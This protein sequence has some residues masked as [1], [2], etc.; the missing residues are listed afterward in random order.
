MITVSAEERQA[1]TIAYFEHPHM[2]RLKEVIT[3]AYADIN[4]DVRF[5]AYSGV[6]S[7]RMLEDGFVDAELI[8]NKELFDANGNSRIVYNLTQPNMNLFC[9][10]G[11]V[12]KESVLFDPEA[13]IG[14]YQVHKKHLDSYYGD[15]IKAQ[16]L[17]I[18]S[19]ERL[20]NLINR[21]NLKHIALA[22]L[23]NEKLPVELEQYQ[24]ETLFQIYG[25]HLVH[26]KHEK[27]IPQLAK[28]IEKYMLIY[29]NKAF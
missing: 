26:K 3:R 6:R 23:H 10:R 9:I 20:M 13:I 5:E 22:I 17:E 15:R 8:R 24:T 7:R 14:A 12:C 27:L 16:I 1:F 19:V 2:A 4:I 18:S 25:V 11:E 21:G 29:P 28:A